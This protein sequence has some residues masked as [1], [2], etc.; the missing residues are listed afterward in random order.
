[1]APLVFVHGCS[2]RRRNIKTV[3]AI[4]NGLIVVT[5]G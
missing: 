1:M 2:V 5:V 4:E 3:V